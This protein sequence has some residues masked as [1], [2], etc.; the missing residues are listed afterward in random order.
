MLRIADPAQMKEMVLHSIATAVGKPRAAL[1]P[2]TR[3]V[4]DLGVDSV[5]K[6]HLLMQLEKDF[7]A[8]IPDEQLVGFSTVGDVTTYVLSLAAAESGS[9]GGPAAGSLPGGHAGSA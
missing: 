8:E 1:Q 7:D 3:F 5:D 6:F 4:E 9:A 2:E